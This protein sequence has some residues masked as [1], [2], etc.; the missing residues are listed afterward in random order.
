MHQENR[1]RTTANKAQ[2]DAPMQDK[3]NER[4]YPIKIH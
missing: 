4:E 1:Q 3:K 2:C